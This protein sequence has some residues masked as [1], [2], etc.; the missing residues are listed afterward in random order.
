MKKK[1][2]GIHGIN[3]DIFILDLCK[4]NHRL[5]IDISKIAFT[6]EF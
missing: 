6:N 2:V 4:R 3:A 5:G 1:K